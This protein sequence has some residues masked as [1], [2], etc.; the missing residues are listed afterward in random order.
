[1][2]DEMPHRAATHGLCPRAIDSH[3]ARPSPLQTVRPPFGED[4]SHLPPLLTLHLYEASGLH[5]VRRMLG[6]IVARSVD[7]RT[8]TERRPYFRLWTLV[9]RTADERPPNRRR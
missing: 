6:V 3:H 4:H 7:M 5:P 8:S 2:A 9:Y 1:M